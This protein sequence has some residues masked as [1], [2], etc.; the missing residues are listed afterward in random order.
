LRSQGTRPEFVEQLNLPRFHLPSL[1]RDAEEVA[2]LQ[3]AC[4]RAGI[5]AAGIGLALGDIRSWDEAESAERSW[6]EGLLRGLR[7]VEDGSLERRASIQWF[8]TPEGPLAGTQAGLALT[9]FLDPTRPV[10]AFSEDR[11]RLRVSGRGTLWLVSQGLD[12]AYVCRTAAEAAGGE[13]G[14]HKVAS[15][16]TIPSGMRET[17]L[18]EADRRVG[19]QLPSLHPERPAT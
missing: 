9:Y 8:D 2:N 12:L 4:G 7:R 18:S 19:H 1:G 17:F 13:G 10:F 15:G 11:D 5:P 14:G 3:N 16:A 6:R